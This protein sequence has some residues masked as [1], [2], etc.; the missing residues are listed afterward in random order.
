MKPGEFYELL[1]DGRYRFRIDHHTIN[2]FNTCDKY[3]E[4]RH[5]TAADGKV[6]SGKHDNPKTR[7]GSWWSRVMELFYREMSFGTRPP[8]EHIM[9]FASDTWMELDMETIKDYDIKVYEK[10]GGMDGGV[11]MA[12][13]YYDAF[14][15]PHFRGWRVIGSELGF[16]WKD[17][18][19]LGEDDKVVVYY[20]GKPDL[21]VL[22]YATNMVMPL[23]HKTKDSV[24]GNANVMFKPH[25]QTAGYIFALRELMKNLPIPEL[26]GVKSAS[27]IAG[28][29]R[30]LGFVEP[31]KCIIMIAARFRPTDKPRNGIRK[32]RFLPVYPVYT[33]DEIEEWRL[34]VM[35]KCRTLRASIERQRWPRRESACHLYSNGCQ[36]RRVCSTPAGSRNIVL[37]SDFV[38]KEPW[39]P[40]DAEETE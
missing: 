20:G 3:F 28:R 40:Y 32:P 18:V 26:A 8:V 13:E 9:R 39:Q 15:A 23:D 29:T 19:F 22:D 2:D 1:P 38:R 11:T 16:G 31:T 14:A 21:V 4:F 35:E 5:I 34:D 17:E 27:E 7:L 36:F 25:P 30:A 6:W 33:S 12:I 24:P 37:A 10:F